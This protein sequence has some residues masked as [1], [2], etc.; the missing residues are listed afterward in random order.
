MDDSV[1]GAGFELMES[2][3]LHFEENDVLDTPI[4][5]ASSGNTGTLPSTAWGILDLIFGALF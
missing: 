3:F 5:G 4:V 1:V 2:V